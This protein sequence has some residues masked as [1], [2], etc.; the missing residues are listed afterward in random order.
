MT[1]KEGTVQLKVKD[2]DTGLLGWEP[3][4]MSFDAARLVLVVRRDN[5]QGEVCNEIEVSQLHCVSPWLGD[6]RIRFDLV[7]QVW[8]EELF[9]F[10]E[11]ILRGALT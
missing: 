8:C 7:S 1:K 11:P 2:P 9:Y 6:H 10:E 3:R 4:H 5:E